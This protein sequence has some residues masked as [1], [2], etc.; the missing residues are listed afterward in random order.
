MSRMSRLSSSTFSAPVGGLSDW[1]SPLQ[2]NLLLGD[3]E[4]TL[5]KLTLGFTLE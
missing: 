1:D 3:L 5:G 2:R 4:L